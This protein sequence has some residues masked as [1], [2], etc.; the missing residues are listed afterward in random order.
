[1]SARAADPVVRE[2]GVADKAH[3]ISRTHARLLYDGHGDQP[4]ALAHANRR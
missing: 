1:M 4:A 2:A 3:Q